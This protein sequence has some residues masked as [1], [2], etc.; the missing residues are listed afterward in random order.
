MRIE[1]GFRRDTATRDLVESTDQLADLTHAFG[2]AI[3]EQLYSVAGIV[4]SAH[5]SV[6]TSFVVTTGGGPP[7][8]AAADVALLPAPVANAAAAAAG[9][10]AAE[11]AVEIALFP[12]TAAVAA[13][14]A[15]AA[16][17]AAAA[18]TDLV[19][20]ALGPSANDLLGVVGSHNWDEPDPPTQP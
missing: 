1:R 14:G 19:D 16:A 9:A 18:E 7:A 4:A 11:A 13:A 3:P 8:A 15:T 20:P 6:G 5:A 10:A 12:V 17:A 2:G